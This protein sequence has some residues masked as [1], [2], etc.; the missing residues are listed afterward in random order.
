MMNTFGP[1]PSLLLTVLLLLSVSSPSASAA[2]AAVADASLTKRTAR[3]GEN[4]EL[5]VTV[6]GLSRPVIKEIGRS[7]ELRVTPLRRGRQISDQEGTYWLFRYR[8]RPKAAGD[9]TIEPIRVFGDGR[10]VLT[11]AL[12]LR[13][14]TVEGKTPYG[15]AEF[16]HAVSIPRALAE[17]VLKAVP[18]PTP[19]PEPVKQNDSRPLPERCLAW[20]GKHLRDFW[21]YPGPGK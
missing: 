3:P 6:R 12:R 20:M 7:P 15:A 8:V 4:V 11:R 14:S 10:E 21:S 13:S 2:T 5:I 16:S 1:Y 17:E 18:Q 19:S 9:F